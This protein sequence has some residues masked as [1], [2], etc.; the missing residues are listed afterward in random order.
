MGSIWTLWEALR[1]RAQVPVCFFLQRESV[2]ASSWVGPH[3]LY[4]EAPMSFLSGVVM[5]FCI[6]AI[7]LPKK[8]YIGVFRYCIGT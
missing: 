2:N 5:V 8:N 6:G 1:L 3:Y 4:L 7:K